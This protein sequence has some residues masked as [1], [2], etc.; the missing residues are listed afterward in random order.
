VSDD[1]DDDALLTLALDHGEAV[2]DVTRAR[3]RRLLRA[4]GGLARA[5]RVL[6]DVGSVC[7]VVGVD[8]VVVARS[9]LAQ[10]L[11]REASAAAPP[12]SASLLRSWLVPLSAAAAALAVFV[13]VGKGG[14]TGPGT[15]GVS[16][17]GQPLV[18]VA[19]REARGPLGSAGVVAGLEA[20]ADDIARC[21]D[22]DVVVDVSFRV[23]GDG[24]VERAT[25]RAADRAVARCVTG[26]IEGTAFA[27]H[28]EAT[29]VD[30][31]I[32]LHPSPGGA[33]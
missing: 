8:P 6:D 10:L 2:D 27:L 15:K 25:G 29:E 16:L 32:E 20:R 3:A 30:A 4:P 33:P 9:P 21:S 28:D 19:V 11:E 5:Y 13:V 12:S 18:L 17:T 26:V 24:L 1:L 23:G 31:G 22:R 14:V 7:G